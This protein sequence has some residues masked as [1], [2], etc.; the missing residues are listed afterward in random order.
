MDPPFPAFLGLKIN[1]LKISSQDSFDCKN[2]DSITRLKQR[3]SPHTAYLLL[4]QGKKSI[5][6]RMNKDHHPI[7]RDK[8]HSRFSFAS[9]NGEEKVEIDAVHKA[10]GREAWYQVS[11][12]FKHV[13]VVERLAVGR[14]WFILS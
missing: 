10:V 8:L 7:V 2:S 1:A 12:R 11:E 6:D 13:L 9:D 4:H 3:R 14:L 5:I